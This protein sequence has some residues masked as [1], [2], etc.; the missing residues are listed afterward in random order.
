MFYVCLFPPS[1]WQAHQLIVLCRIDVLLWV[2]NH[3]TVVV[4]VV[5]VTGREVPTRD[6]IDC[7]RIVCVVGFRWSAAGRVGR[8]LFFCEIGLRSTRTSFAGTGLQMVSARTRRAACLLTESTS[9]EL[10]K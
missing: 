3:D 6:D 9:C 7:V 8:C 5:V 1:S 4:V 10:R 2:M